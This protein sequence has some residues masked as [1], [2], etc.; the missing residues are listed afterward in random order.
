VCFLLFLERAHKRD[1]KHELERYEWQL[2]QNNAPKKEK[3]E[4]DAGDLSG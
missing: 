2:N 3:R 4:K 1:I